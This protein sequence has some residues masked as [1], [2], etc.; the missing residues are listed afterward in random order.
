M[1]SLVGSLA[2][3]VAVV[4][5]VCI[6]WFSAPAEVRKDLLRRLRK[7]GP[8]GVELDAASKEI[9]AASQGAAQGGLSW[10]GVAHGSKSELASMPTAKAALEVSDTKVLRDTQR[11]IDAAARWGWVAAG[12]DP[13]EFPH[14]LVT[15]TRD[16]AKIIGSRVGLNAGDTVTFAPGSFIDPNT[17]KPNRK[18][19]SI[20]WQASDDLAIGVESDGPGSASAE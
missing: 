19:Y 5:L 17:G 9:T 16:G 14:P 4:V 18:S 15:W 20:L 3:P 10:T 7:A 2:W 8:S 1:A 12:S 13:Y 11:L 6:I